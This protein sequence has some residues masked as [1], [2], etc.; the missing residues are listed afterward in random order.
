MAQDRDQIDSGAV[1]TARV[2]GRLADLAAL[3]DAILRLIGFGHRR[4]AVVQRDV[5]LTLAQARL[6]EMLVA[7]G[8]GQ[9]LHTLAGQTGFA[10]PTLTGTMDRLAAAGLIERRRHATDRRVIDI[11]L[12]EAGQAC[13]TRYTARQAAR[14]TA[15]TATFSDAE[16]ATF[17]RLLDRF[18]AAL[19]DTR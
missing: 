17:T 4:N 10:G 19:E 13:Y 3:G 8:G 12:T 9:T 14:L 7:G 1:P 15:A 5:G 2:T 6:L 11:T 18:I 16:L